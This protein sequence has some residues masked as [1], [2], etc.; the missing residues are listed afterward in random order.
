MTATSKF[1]AVHQICCGTRK[2]S[3]PHCCFVMSAPNSA[4]E[5]P[6]DKQETATSLQAMK[7]PEVLSTMVFAKHQAL[8][9]GLGRR[10]GQ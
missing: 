10:S 5:S 8:E 6:A 1:I 4:T 7:P 3:K 2:P 9:R